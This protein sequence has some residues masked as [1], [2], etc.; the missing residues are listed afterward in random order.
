MPDATLSIISCGNYLN[1]RLSYTNKEE[2]DSDDPRLPMVAA[3][4]KG[5][6]DHLLIAHDP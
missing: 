3:R 6:L 2:V 1:Y 4:Y 5:P